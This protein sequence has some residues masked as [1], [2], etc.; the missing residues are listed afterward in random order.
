MQLMKQ[1]LVLNRQLCEAGLTE[2]VAERLLVGTGLGGRRREDGGG[3]GPGAGAGQ[4]GWCGA[5]ASASCLPSLAPGAGQ[6]WN[7][8]E[9][10]PRSP[11]RPKVVK[12][13]VRSG[14]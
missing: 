12:V 9:S 13:A 4:Q 3:G 7:S 6:W 14:F 5:G 11:A 2:S 8:C 10:W 1:H